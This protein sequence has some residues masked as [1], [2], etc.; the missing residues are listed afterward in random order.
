MNMIPFRPWPVEHKAVS[1]VMRYAWP[2]FD[3]LFRPSRLAPD[4]HDDAVSLFRPSRLAADEQ[5][6]VA[7]SPCTRA[8]AVRMRE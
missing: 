3:R 7:A 5:D 6:T 1:S 8:L 2:R 4:E